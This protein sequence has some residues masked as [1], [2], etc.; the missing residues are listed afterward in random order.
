MDEKDKKDIQESTAKFTFTVVL[1][2]SL[3]FIVVIG[4]IWLIQML[5]TNSAGLNAVLREWAWR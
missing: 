3:I 5:F 2:K 1:L 4:I